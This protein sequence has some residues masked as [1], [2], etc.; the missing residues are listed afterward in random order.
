MN[1]ESAPRFRLFTGGPLETNAHLFEA[2][3]GTI[4]FDAPEGADEAFAGETIALLFLTHGHF[5]HVGD[6]AAV[7]RRHGCPVAAHPLTIPMVSDPGFFR[8]WGFPIE[9]EP[10]G[11]T[12]IL[13]EGPAELL[14]E[15]CHLHHVP[16]H[17]PG[18]L[19]VHFPGHGALVG[20]DVL[21]AGGI[22]RWDL[23]GGDHAALLENL[24]AKILP[25]PDNTLVLPGHGPPTTIAK[26]RSTNPFLMG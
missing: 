1:A 4:L 12:Q 9:I 7:Q 26:E 19:C 10:V 6:A 25:L 22:G 16:G 13:E 2:P 14:G 24:H 18:S 20:G 3:G 17:C 8:A 11:V 21:F 5:D 23:P 15:A